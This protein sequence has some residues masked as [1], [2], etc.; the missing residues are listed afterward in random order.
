M[1]DQLDAETI[2]MHTA[3]VFADMIETLR[4]HSVTLRS[5]VSTI[6]VTTLVLEGWSSKLD[7]DLHILDTMREMLGGDDL[8]KERIGRTVDRICH[9]SAP[10]SL[11]WH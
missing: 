2:R 10:P 7:P 9:A 11:F 6:V 1:F 4:R 3:E 8:I 5:T